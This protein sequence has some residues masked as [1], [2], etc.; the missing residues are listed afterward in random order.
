[1][2]YDRDEQLRRIFDCCNPVLDADEQIALMLHEVCG[3]TYAQVAR[4][5]LAPT[6]TMARRLVEARAR[7]FGETTHP[8][9]AEPPWHERLA[10]VMAGLYLLFNEG[11]A[12][13]SGGSHVR[14]KL[15]ADAIV[16][17]RLLR[18]RF[19]KSPPE[20]DALLGLM[21]LQDAR[22]EARVDAA[23][24]LVPLADQ[25]RARWNQALIAEGCTLVHDALRRGQP[26]PYALQAAIAAVHAQA[27]QAADTD[28]R[29]IAAL[30]T[31]LL[32]HQP[33]PVVA[34][35][36]ALAVSMCDGPLVALPL[37]EA[38]GPALEQYHVW[39]ASRA[40]LLRRLQRFDEAI[41]SY[42][43]AHA[44]AGNHAERRFIAR[45]LAE[46]EDRAGKPS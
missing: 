43:R 17:T 15:C 1:M 10:A 37:L 42:R 33:S 38:I 27:R 19:V 11:Y 18:S 26:S 21:L 5:F 13:T 41:A 24:D 4:A 9:D 23:G 40:D 16:L 39:H 3:L 14:R 2:Q 44:L 46:L 36:H 32:S 35:N 8:M 29:E 45:R 34:L 7:A 22:C 12:A 20:L 30:Y 28:W 31:R 6:M 25:D